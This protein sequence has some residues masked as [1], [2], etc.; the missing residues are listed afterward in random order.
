MPYRSVVQMPTP[1][2]GA[3]VYRF[4]GSGFLAESNGRNQ[5]GFDWLYLAD[6]A[7]SDGF[8]KN[9]EQSLQ[10]LLQ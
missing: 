9:N 2:Y 5:R 6:L 8:A 4:I 1:C 7:D 3:G 10:V